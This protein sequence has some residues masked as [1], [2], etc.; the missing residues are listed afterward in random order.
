MLSHAPRSQTGQTC[1]LQKWQRSTRI[2]ALPAQCEPNTNL[3][4]TAYVTGYAMPSKRASDAATHARHV[5]PKQT[6]RKSFFDL[7]LLY[8]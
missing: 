1:P 6:V 2:S 4:Y 7:K 5:E 3:E 8:F